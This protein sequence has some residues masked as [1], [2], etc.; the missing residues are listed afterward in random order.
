[1]VDAAGKFLPL[2][3][4]REHRQPHGSHGSDGG[5]AAGCGSSDRP[6]GGRPGYLPIL[7]NP[8]GPG[9]GR[10]GTASSSSRSDFGMTTA[11]SRSSCTKFL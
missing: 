6:P 7:R 11:A 8:A 9:T 10:T 5:A 4:V 3:R 1:M 2:R